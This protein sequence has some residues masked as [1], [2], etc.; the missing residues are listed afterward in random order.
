MTGEDMEKSTHRTGILTIRGIRREGDQEEVNEL[1]TTARYISRD[2]KRYLFYKEYMEGGTHQQVRLTMSDHE[3]ILKKK[4]WGESVLHFRKG[5]L[6]H[7]RYQTVAGPM[8]LESRTRKIHGKE[9]QDS[10][11]LRIEYSLYMHGQLLSEYELDL[12]W[13][14]NE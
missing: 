9:T 8:D 10:L 4:G 13:K 1:K 12:A 6:K 5:A 3:V 2:G 14:E 11:Y 7:C